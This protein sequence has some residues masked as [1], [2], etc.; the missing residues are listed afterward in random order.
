MDAI[1]L[2]SYAGV[3]AFVVAIWLARRRFPSVSAALLIF[4]LITLPMLGIV[5]NGP[6]ITADRYTY[7]AAAAL[8]ILVA[9]ATLG[10]PQWRMAIRVC[11]GVVIIL[12]AILTWNQTLV[13]RDSSSLWARVIDLHAESALAQTGY[14]NELMKS[15][16]SVPEALVHYERAIELDPKSADNE[17]NLG[18]ALASINHFPEA[19][20]HYRRALQLQ[21]SQITARDNLARAE[22]NVAIELAKA[23][24]VAEAEP[25]FHEAATLEPMLADV[26]YNWGYALLSNGRAGDA[27]AHLRRAVELRPQDADA[28]LSL[29]RALLLERQIPAAV[30]ELQE[31]LR[32]DPGNADARQYLD[33]VRAPSPGPR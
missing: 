33:R 32:I 15:Q 19:I 22:S 27:I 23:G 25:H 28:H 18:V 5:Q 17:D 4:G 24:R 20:Q 3:A 29:A 1:F 8:A 30:I 7:H 16:D 6:Q 26:E 11:A 10:A 2:A 12:L 13:W 31:T 9:G 14:A 21:P